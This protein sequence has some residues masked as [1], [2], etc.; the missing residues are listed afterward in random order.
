MRTYAGVLN[1]LTHTCKYTHTGVAAIKA[2][3]CIVSI[4]A[5]G[6]TLLQPIYKQVS[7][8]ALFLRTYTRLFTSKRGYVTSE[9]GYVHSLVTEGVF[10]SKRGYVHK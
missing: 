8:R 5:G 4:I 7:L 10:T 6:R 1:T 3:V 2:C 9:R